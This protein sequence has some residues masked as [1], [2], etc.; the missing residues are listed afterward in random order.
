MSL[1]HHVSVRTL[2]VVGMAMLLGGATSVWTTLRIKVRRTGSLVVQFEL[3]F[4]ATM[5]LMLV[6]GVGNLGAL[7]PPGPDTR[8]GTV[9]TVKLMLVSL[10]VLGSVIR[11]LAVIEL[12]NRDA[13]IR[14]P[15]LRRSYAAT[16]WSLLIIV[17]L[18]EVLA[19]G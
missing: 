12:E 6:T 7:G 16:A 5:G 11:T 15:G 14:S 19:H 1:I 2:H 18:A 4:W 3:L 13:P 8:W 9:L 17:A 10:F